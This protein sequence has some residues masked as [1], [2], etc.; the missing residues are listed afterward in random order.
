MKAR[1][2]ATI[3]CL[4]LARCKANGVSVLHLHE[5]WKDDAVLKG[6]GD[7]YQIEGILIHADLACQTRC[8]VT[9][10]ERSS[11][12]VDAYPE[13]SDSDL[14][15]CLAHNICYGGR[16]AW[17]DLRGIKVRWVRLIVEGDEEDVGDHRRR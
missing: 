4:W 15:L 14:E 13:V 10:Q 3:L 12:W 8:V 7:P 5:V 16:D 6:T 9:A 17:I 11:V 2:I 1:T